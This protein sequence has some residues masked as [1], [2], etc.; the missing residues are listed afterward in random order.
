MSASDDAKVSMFQLD[1]MNWTE[2]SVHMRGYLMM[3]RLWCYVDGDTYKLSPKMKYDAEVKAAATAGTQSTT[4]IAPV[5]DDAQE[6]WDDDDQQALGIIMVWTQQKLHTHLDGI[7]HAH[8]AW[9]KLHTVYGTESVL[10]TWN[11]VVGYMN[12][13]WTIPSHFDNKSM[14]WRHREIVSQSPVSRLRIPGPP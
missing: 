3:K 8:G 13:R 4:T 7:P 6:A 14:T 10:G 12:T 2:W 5:D 1:G 9:E 11:L